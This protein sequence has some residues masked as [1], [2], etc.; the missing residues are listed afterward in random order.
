MH[1]RSAPGLIGEADGDARRAETDR[2]SGL[3]DAVFGIGRGDIARG[4]GRGSNSKSVVRRQ[5]R[6]ACRGEV[7]PVPVQQLEAP[8]PC[9]TETPTPEDEMAVPLAVVP[10]LRV[11]LEVAP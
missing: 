9:W 8:L 1:S 5:V 11:Q 7:G 2:I 6:W 4:Q 3:G 10:I